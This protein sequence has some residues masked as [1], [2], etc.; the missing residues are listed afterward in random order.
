MRHATVL[1]VTWTTVVLM[2]LG[3]AGE[4][5]RDRSLILAM[6]MYIPLAPVGLAAVALDL[7]RRGRS[8]RPRFAL[9]IGGLVAL[10]VG[11]VPML[12]TRAPDPPA[13]GSDRVTLLHWNM[14][15]GGR[16]AAQS[17]WDR[18]AEQILSRQP[19]V[20][21]LSEAPP[22]GWLFNTLHT[23]GR[24]H[25]TVHISNEPGASY[26]YK[27]LVCSRFPM[28]MEGRIAVRNGVAMAVTV[29]V[30]GRPLRLLVVDGVSNVGVLRTPFLSDVAAACDAAAKA[31]RP[32]DIVVGDFNAP[33]RSIG[34]D[35]VRSAAGGHKRASDYSRGWRATWPMPL[36]V[37]DI[38]HVLV[39]SDT[40]VVGCDIFSSLRL[41]TDHRGQYV[42]LA[43]PP[44]AE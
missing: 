8:L 40:A 35:A 24:G 1:T 42:T 4:I 26:W 13:P 10:A 37:Y 14:Q 12:G 27:P 15:S 16:L 25:R 2:L 19:D 41:D 9:T 29:R 3:A 33:G 7:V 28:Q 36:P 21:V 5:L 30:R 38:D 34:F 32:F 23:N 17:R 39:R 44:A 31:G 22:D 11:A 20:I 6:F 43:L 18:A